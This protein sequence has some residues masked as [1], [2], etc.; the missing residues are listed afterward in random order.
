LPIFKLILPSNDTHTLYDTRNETLNIGSCLSR[1][2]DYNYCKS[3][4][5]WFK[6]V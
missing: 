6:C 4:K 1:E 3:V 5:V 2:Q